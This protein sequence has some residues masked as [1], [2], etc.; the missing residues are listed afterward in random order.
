MEV[1]VMALGIA[2]GKSYFRNFQ[3]GKPSALNLLI[4]LIV[5]MTKLSL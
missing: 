4:L 3:I 2:S 5:R 1:A